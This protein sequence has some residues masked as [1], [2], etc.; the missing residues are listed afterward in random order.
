MLCRLTQT[1]QSPRA[2]YFSLLCYDAVQDFCPETC[3]R[4]IDRGA[5]DSSSR[6]RDIFELG[7]PSPRAGWVSS[8]SVSM[9][10]SNT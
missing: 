8:S 2:R 9:S 4:P 5:S 1:A 6:I 3:G 7:I 10:S